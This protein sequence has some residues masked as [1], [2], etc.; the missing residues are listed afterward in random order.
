MVVGYRDYENLLLKFSSNGPCKA[1]NA[2]FRLL[3]EQS[4][5]TEAYRQ[6][7]STYCQFTVNPHDLLKHGCSS[8]Q[9]NGFIIQD[10]ARK[11]RVRFDFKARLDSSYAWKSSY[12]QNQRYN[13]LVVV[14]FYSPVE[15]SSKIG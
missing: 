8:H 2:Q 1:S 4:S 10:P 5:K 7:N 9:E 13:F 11:Y 3:D 14:G 6:L 12:C 15:S